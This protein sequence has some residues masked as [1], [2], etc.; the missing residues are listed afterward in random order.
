MD[1]LNFK[2]E[3]LIRSFRFIRFVNRFGG[4]SMVVINALRLLLRDWPKDKPVEILDVGCGVGD[5]GITVCRW[6]RAR[7][8]SIRYIGLDKNEDI[9]NLA[10]PGISYIKGDLFGQN[11][12]EADFVIASMLLHHMEDNKIPVVIRR[13]AEKSR[14]AVIINDL[15]RSII[16]YIFCSIFL[17]NRVT[18]HDAL[19]SIRKGFRL[20]ELE[21]YGIVRKAYAWRLL[22]I[23]PKGGAV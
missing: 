20:E 4:G 2:G 1:D 12:P 23:V 19:L 7:G 18:R 14:H 8:F 22:L 10:S 6:A 9:L 15:R 3:G 21:R 16:P 11:L 5:I 17:R 13:L